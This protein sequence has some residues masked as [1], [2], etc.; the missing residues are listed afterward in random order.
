MGG[1]R[2]PKEFDV[3]ANLLNIQIALPGVPFA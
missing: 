3:Y 1:S 2:M